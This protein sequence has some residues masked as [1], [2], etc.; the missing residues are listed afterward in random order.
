[1]DP[2]NMFTSGENYYYTPIYG[3]TACPF[4][5]TVKGLK[6]L[7]QGCSLKCFKALKIQSVRPKSILRLT[8]TGQ[9][10]ELSCRCQRN[11]CSNC[12]TLCYLAKNSPVSLTRHGC[13]GGW[14]RR[15]EGA[16]GSWGSRTTPSRCPPAC[17]PSGPEP[18]GCSPYPHSLVGE[19]FYS[20]RKKSRTWCRVL[21]KRFV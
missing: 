4:L 19:C 21:K 2:L 5:S 11:M 13:T 6:R 9:K 17:R 1:M 12:F 16:G 14:P 10:Q 7:Y 18:A 8:S 15:C 3:V 20:G